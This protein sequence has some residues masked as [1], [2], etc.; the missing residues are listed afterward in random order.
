MSNPVD[1]LI[2]AFGKLPGVGEKTAARL[3]FFLLRAPKAAAKELSEALKDLHEKIKL[4]SLCCNV[5][6]SDPCRICTDPRRDAHL[7]C[8]VEEPSDVA[9]IEKT[10]AYRGLYHVLHGA[11]SPL[12]GIGP[13]DLKIQELLRRLQDSQAKEII[14]ATNANVEGDATSLYLVRLLRP[15]GLCLSRLGMGVPVGGQLEYLDP[16]TLSKALEE[17]REII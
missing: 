2:H 16:S 7:I 9:A 14:L 5:T 11:L 15:I 8:V 4:C 3:V 6:N 10:A 12:E 1:R 13:G 17:R